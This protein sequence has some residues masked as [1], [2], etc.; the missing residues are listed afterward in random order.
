MAY[1]NTTYKAFVAETAAKVTAEISKE[2]AYA[3]DVSLL[4]DDGNAEKIAI[5]AVNVA[6]KLAMKL[7]EWWRGKGDHSTVM[8]DVDDTPLTRVENAIYDMAVK[9]QQS[10]DSLEDIRDALCDTGNIDINPIQLIAE[11]VHKMQGDTESIANEV[12][13][14]VSTTIED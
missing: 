4:K 1:M 5:A 12:D 10:A 6:E 13:K 7:E 8:F 14:L 11:S 9:L 3:E 2:Y